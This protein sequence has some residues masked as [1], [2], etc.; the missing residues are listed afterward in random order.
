M[1][2]PF[3]VWFMVSNSMAGDDEKVIY[4]FAPIVVTGQRYEMPQK[5]VAASISIIKPNELRRTQ[6]NTAAEVISYLVPGVFTTRRATMGYGVSALAAG[7]VT[8]RG[9]GGN[10]NNQVLILID[11]RP[12]YQGIFSHPLSDAY[13]LDNVDH[14]EVIRGPASSVY[15]TNALGGVINIITKKLLVKGFETNVSMQYASFN[16]QKYLLQ[17]QG[18]IGQFQYFASASYNRSDG[19]RDKSDFAGQN[20]ALKLGYRLTPHYQLG[21]NGSLT[22]YQFNDPGPEGVSLSGYFDRGDIVRSSM[23]ITLTNEFAKTDG[24]IKIH[25]NFGRHDLSDGWKSD[26]QTNGMIAFQNIHLPRDIKS[27]IGFDIKRFGGT[28]KSGSDNLG[29]F[30]NDEYA[31]Y[32]HFQKIWF[33]KIIFA[34]GVRHENNSQFG[35]EW[36]PRVGLVFHPLS[37][38]AFRMSASKG[39]RTPSIKDL[40]LFPP[41]NAQLKPERLYSYEL[42]LNQ[43]FGTIADV[44]VCGYF[45]TGNQ[46]IETIA[47]A[48]GRMQNQNSGSNQA[49][50]FEIALQFLPISN[51]STSISYSY[52]DSEEILPYAPNKLNFVM[53]YRLK[54]LE[55]SLYSEYIAD[56]YTSYQLN[57]MPPRT[58]IEKS[59][60]YALIHLKLVHPIVDRLRLE[61]GVENVMDESYEILKGY[62]MPGRTFFTML[63]YTF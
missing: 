2:T 34:A 4:E 37:Q 43:T 21:F 54:R 40:Y 55:L 63:N 16:T 13:L 1:L 31:F 20:Y 39:F 5:D 38:T 30:F 48:P 52:L 49:M 18:S 25:G 56:L 46:L 22:P 36:I 28:A 61:M 50:G 29:T 27:T 12:D 3:I 10:P 44:D 9:I 7:G 53:S 19:H 41:A 51:L 35:G 59:A 26:D 62:P 14:I 24:S 15:G 60:D 33:S 23:D 32:L 11:G 58:T 45:Y 57:Q 6:L 47:I 17:H 8:I 42:G